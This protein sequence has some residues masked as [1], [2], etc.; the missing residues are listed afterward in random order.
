[1]GYADGDLNG[2]TVVNGTDFAILA[3][4]FGKSVPAAQAAPLAV[5]Q[6]SASSPALRA[7]SSPPATVR[8]SVKVLPSS[9]RRAQPRKVLPEARRV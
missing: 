4:N 1:V 6:P 2:D 9:R 7:A 5:A 8:T 3:G